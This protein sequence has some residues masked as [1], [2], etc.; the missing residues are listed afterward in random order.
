MR[1]LLL[2]IVYTLSYGMGLLVYKSALWIIWGE[3]LGGDAAAVVFWS[4][5][6]YIPIGIVYLAICLL[7]KHKVSK[8]SLRYSLYPMACG[9]LFVVPTM[10]ILLLFGGGIDRLFSPEAQLFHLLFGSTGVT[11]G[12]GYGFVGGR[13]EKNALV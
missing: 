11:F 4:A 9:S 2:C 8:S 10:L 6:A 13:Y 3:P 1:Y 5:L 7:I 12:L